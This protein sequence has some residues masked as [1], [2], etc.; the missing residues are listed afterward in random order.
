V[1]GLDC[2]EDL[3]EALVVVLDLGRPGN[4]VGVSVVPRVLVK[5]G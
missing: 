5:K 2:L 3:C 1:A 4:V